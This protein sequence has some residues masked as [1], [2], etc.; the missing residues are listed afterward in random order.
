MLSPLIMSSPPFPN[1]FVSPFSTEM[2]SSEKLFRNLN[3]WCNWPGKLTGAI[4]VS[5]E[6]EVWC[7][8]NAKSTLL[9]ASHPFVDEILFSDLTPVVSFDGRE[10][11]G[12]LNQDTKKD[13]RNAGSLVSDTCP[14]IVPELEVQVPVRPE[15][16]QAV[17][18][19]PEKDTPHETLHTSHPNEQAD[20]FTPS[21]SGSVLRNGHTHDGPLSSE[22][23]EMFK[24]RFHRC[25][26]SVETDSEDEKFPSTLRKRTAKAASLPDSVSDDERPFGGEK[27][28]DETRASLKRQKSSASSSPIPSNS[29]TAKCTRERS[30]IPR[31]VS[32]TSQALSDPLKIPLPTDSVP[33]LDE[34][35]RR[36]EKSISPVEKDGSADPVQ[37][38]HGNI[39]KAVSRDTMTPLVSP[40]TRTSRGFSNGDTGEALKNGPGTEI[41]GASADTPCE[42]TRM[43]E[44]VDIAFGGIPTQKTFFVQP[45]IP[46]PPT[47]PYSVP[48]PY[49]NRDDMVFQVKCPS[50]VKPAWYK[51]SVQF[52]V[53]LIIHPH[54]RG[55]YEL[56]VPGLPRL[57]VL[58][59]GSLHLDI[60]AHRGLEIRTMHFDTYKLENGHLEAQFSSDGTTLVIPLRFCDSN[61]YGFLRDSTINQ[62]IRSKVKA[63]DHDSNSCIVEYTAVCSLELFERDFWAEKCGF[64]LYIHDG[65]AGDYTCQLEKPKANF[66]TI[67]LTS[68]PESEFGMARLLVICTPSNRDMFAIRWEMRLPRAEAGSWI[69]RITALTRGN[70]AEEKLQSRY[71]K[72]ATG[73]QEI[74]RCGTKARIVT[75]NESN[76]VTPADSNVVTP[77]MSD[78]ATPEGSN[79]KKLF[80]PLVMKIFLFFIALFLLLQPLAYSIG[81][82]DGVLRDDGQKARD[83][84]CVNSRLAVL[85]SPW[86]T[87]GSS[88]PEL[89]LPIPVASEV[90]EVIIPVRN[91]ESSPCLPCPGLEETDRWP[92]KSIRPPWTPIT[93]R[94]H[95]DYWLGWKGPLPD[96][97]FS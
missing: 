73:G 95:I 82:Y 15:K 19:T 69:P 76:S 68:N 48:S 10:C 5:F 33:I 37:I 43:S 27:L 75:P 77:E 17:P 87:L 22:T 7:E 84:F 29:S 44:S 53:S 83:F 39:V 16:Q 63:D 38:G 59:H 71:L 85:K 9:D 56:V 79:G 3:V 18:E 2:N 46:P 57:N 96:D 81:L 70:R 28:D 92:T 40:S 64:Y 13:T 31:P 8:P 45:P 58:D 26:A 41:I 30:F 54:S 61:F 89:I 11:F 66:N 21:D 74:V 52:T 35:L 55:W 93:V 91:V 20:T 14:W 42:Q 49:L 90:T 86:E 34:E 78:A 23:F 94:D 24:D 12:L 32:V 50:G 88:R 72:A 80:I 65:P 97:W 1:L 51:A 60:P 25:Q 67:Q 62:T 47:P 4:L 6:V 36:F